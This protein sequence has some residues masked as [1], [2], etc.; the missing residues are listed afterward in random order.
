MRLTRMGSRGSSTSG[1]PSEARGA[2]IGEAGWDTSLP[3]SRKSGPRGGDSMAAW[4][5]ARLRAA[6]SR[7]TLT[8][9]AW[10]HSTRTQ[11]TPASTGRGKRTAARLTES[12]HALASSAPSRPST[13]G[14]WSPTT[15]QAGS[16][17]PRADLPRPS[18]HWRS[19]PRPAA[20]AEDASSCTWPS[21]TPNAAH[22]RP[23]TSASQ[24]TAV[25]WGP[26]LRGVPAS[27]GARSGWRSRRATRQAGTG[28]RGSPRARCASGSS[29]P[30]GASVLPPTAA[31]HPRSRTASTAA[32][33]PRSALAAP[34]RSPRSSAADARSMRAAA[35]RNRL[36]RSRRL[37]VVTAAS[38][39]PPTWSS[40]ARQSS[41]R[42]LCSP[43]A[44]RASSTRLA[45]AADSSPGRGTAQGTAGS[46]TQRPQ[47]SSHPNLVAP[48]HRQASS[49]CWSWMSVRSRSSPTRS[50][51]ARRCEATLAAR[52]RGA[53]RGL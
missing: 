9:G 48:R 12:I 49:C 39:R 36:E 51:S 16:C 47:A 10:G 38:C 37:Q 20:P 42:S 25:A 29:A 31:I 19:L 15:A 44:T 41:T 23:A 27:C 50:R 34:R 33:S 40:R 52:R 11:P 3:G 4:R 5:P 53:G 17:S 46:T 43:S 45:I 30:T 7:S 14:T 21:A 8:T 18:A 2:V 22:G 28:G 26:G 35:A 24:E 6:A 1:G 13:R 32:S